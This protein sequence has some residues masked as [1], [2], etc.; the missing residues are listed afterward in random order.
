MMRLEKED[1]E[2]GGHGNKIED[3]DKQNKANQA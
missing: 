1:E 3:M 2:D